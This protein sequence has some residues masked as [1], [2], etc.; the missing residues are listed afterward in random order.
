MSLS[1]LRRFPFDRIKIDQS[2]IRE[3]PDSAELGAIVRAI[4]G[5]GQNL[6][7]ATV[8]EGVEL[9]ELLGVM[10]EEGCAEAQGFVLSSAMPPDEVRAFLDRYTSADQTGTA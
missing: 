8:A 6:G 1:Y 10:R 4:I 3:M 2:F 5:L 7:V 9:F